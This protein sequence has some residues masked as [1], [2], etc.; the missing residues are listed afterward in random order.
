MPAVQNRSLT[1]GGTSARSPSSPIFS[2]WSSTFDSSPANRSTSSSESSRRASRATCRTWSRLSMGPI[3]GVRGRRRPELGLRAG[4]LSAD[5][6]VADRLPA[7]DG[8][9]DGGEQGDPRAGAHVDQLVR[10]GLVDDAVGDEEHAQRAEHD[11]QHAGADGDRRAIS[12]GLEDRQRDREQG[13]EDEHDVEHVEGFEPG[14]A[15]GEVDAHELPVPVEEERYDEPHAAGGG[16]PFAVSQPPQV[17]TGWPARARA[18]CSVLR[19]SIAIVIGPTPP[20]T[21]V[22]RLARSAAPANSTSPARPSTVR[23]IP[24][25]ITT[26]PSFTQ[27]PRTSPA[28]PT[29][30][31]STSARRH[32]AARSRVREWQVVT[33]ALAASSSAASGLPTRSERPTTTA[34]APSSATSCLR[35]SSI[36]PCGVQGRSPGRP[37][38]SSPVAIGVSPSTSLAGS[39]IS[40][41]APPSTWGGVGSWSRTPDTPGSSLSSRSS[42][43]TSSCEASCGRR[44]SNPSMPTSAQARC[45]PLTY[46]A[47]A[48]S[49]PTSTVASPG[50][51]CPASTHAATSAASSARTC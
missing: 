20:G 27:S 33:V 24:T 49:S 42:R 40:V 5:A 38:A 21:G 31:T 14:E 29:A 11:G 30:A 18:A 47:D 25:S 17:H 1:P 28:R 37:F 13:D 45:L 41:S 4:G 22:I 2:M 16:D 34:S 43:S 51:A 15:D 46:T 32:T 39:M 36:T 44:W 50:G 48:G 7:P 26:A 6:L 12:D 35:S 3:L 9:C 23:F 10:P 19:S 8:D